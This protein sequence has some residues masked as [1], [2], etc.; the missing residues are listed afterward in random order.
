MDRR[1]KEENSKKQQ[2]LFL[3][4][5]SSMT[6][7]SAKTVTRKNASAPICVS[8][9]LYFVLS[10]NFCLDKIPLNSIVEMTL[11]SY[12]DYEIGHFYHPVSKKGL[13]E[14]LSKTNILI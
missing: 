1:F 14:L 10:F 8:S 2:F 3:L 4:V 11:T 9:N 12:N 13:I 5:V 7:K 6:T